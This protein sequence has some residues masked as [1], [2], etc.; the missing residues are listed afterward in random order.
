MTETT[1]PLLHD[2]TR[3]ILLVLAILGLT[4]MYLFQ[5][6]NFLGFFSALVGYQK[7]FHPYVTFVVNKTLRTII[8]DLACCL[9]IFVFFREPKYL[10]VGLGFFLLEI[11]VLLP[12]YFVIKL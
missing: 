9:L 8:N 2:R 11:I 10:R 4:S 6:F 3:L 12:L 5:R 1:S 7:G